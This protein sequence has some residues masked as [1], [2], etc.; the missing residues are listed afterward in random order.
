[1]KENV[2]GH[3]NTIQMLYDI[4]SVFNGSVVEH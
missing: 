1:M 4:W 2:V 3:L